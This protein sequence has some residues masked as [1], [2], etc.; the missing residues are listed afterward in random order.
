MARAWM[1]FFLLGVL[2]NVQARDL[3]GTVT[4]ED[5]SA[6]EFATVGIFKPGKGNR[7]Q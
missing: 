7:L 1:A 4:G 3:L 5:G 2:I 6:I